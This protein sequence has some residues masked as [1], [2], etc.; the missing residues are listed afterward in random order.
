MS[1]RF[2]PFDPARLP[3]DARAVYDRIMS[4][5]GYI[6][7]PYLFWLAAPGFT[8]RIE[9]VE[10]YLRYGVSLGERQVE[11]ITLVV[12]KHW[13]ARYVW[14][15]HR[16]SAEKV[17]VDPAVVEAIRSGAE[18]DFDNEDERVCYEASKALV[19]GRGLDDAL[20]ARTVAA[21]GERG[22][23]ELLGLIGL[24]TSVCLTMVAYR[25]PTK[26]GEPDPL[27]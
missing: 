12:A 17:G 18:P 2:E 26:Y 27:P 1:E 4:E 19:D 23:S 13:R 3:A 9:P 25:M 11:V 7:G 20:W 5:R 6:P 10:E 16:P 21:I 15:S 22:L 24:Y 8:D 14:T